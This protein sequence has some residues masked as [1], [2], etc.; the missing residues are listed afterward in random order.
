LGEEQLAALT[1][2]IAA[3][4]ADPAGPARRPAPDY[5]LADEDLTAR[6]FAEL[7]AATADR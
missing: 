6:R 1:A 7:L 5:L 2:A 3:E 4:T